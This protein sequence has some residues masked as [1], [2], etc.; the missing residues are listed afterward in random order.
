[1]AE[2]AESMEE[3]R[4]EANK[5]A[6]EQIVNDTEES[7]ESIIDSFWNLSGQAIES[8][9]EIMKAGQQ[10]KGLANLL[11]QVIFKEGD[12]TGAL[13][14]I[15]NKNARIIRDIEKEF[16]RGEIDETQRLKKL[17][18]AAE[19]YE[20]A[21]YDLNQEAEEASKVK[22]AD[23]L[24]IE[25]AGIRIEDA[26]RALSRSKRELHAIQGNAEGINGEYQTMIDQAEEKK[27]IDEQQEKLAGLEAEREKEKADAAAEAARAAEKE[28]NL[29]QSNLDKIQRFEERRQDI[30]LSLGRSF[31][32]LGPDAE[33]EDLAA[34]GTRFGQRTSDIITDVERANL[35][36]SQT[37]ATTDDA[38]LNAL[39]NTLNQMTAALQN[40]SVSVDVN[41]L[42][43]QLTKTISDYDVLSAKGRL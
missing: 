14:E 22:L 41:D 20:D 29:L 33:A 43:A 6:N 5:E 9:G 26:A 16:E 32:D 30:A 40:I 21:I 12:L 8:F 39:L 28:A 18:D 42:S 17:R 2:A 11:D 25:G 31:A 35:G 27:R 19:D 34:L 24:D 13:E 10:F 4:T 1:M 36:I 3:R 23:A 7:T 37:G 15:K 38:A